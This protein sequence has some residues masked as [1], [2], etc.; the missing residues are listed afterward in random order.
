[1]L[2]SLGVYWYATA[3][4]GIVHILWFIHCSTVFVWCD[5]FIPTAVCTIHVFKPQH[6]VGTNCHLMK[7]A[8]NYSHCASEWPKNRLSVLTIFKV[9]LGKDFLDCN[10]LVFSVFIHVWSAGLM[11]KMLETQTSQFQSTVLTGTEQHGLDLCL[12]L[13]LYQYRCTSQGFVCWGQ[14]AKAPSPFEF[15]QNQ[16]L[17]QN[18]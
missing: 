1:M 18:V 10:C 4:L 16:F 11:F 6:T 3:L 14:G 12:S 15:V 8:I 7:P 2:V 17:M 9:W 5:A 13:R